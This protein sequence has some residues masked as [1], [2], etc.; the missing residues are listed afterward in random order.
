[1]RIYVLQLLARS[2]LEVG[3][4][5]G[6]YALYGMAVPS[7]YACSGPPCPHTVD[8]FVSRPTEKTIFL[9]IMYAVSLLCLALNFWEML[10]LGVGTICD[11]LGSQ[12]SPA[13]SNDEAS[14][15]YGVA[16]GPATEPAYGN[17][18]FSWNTPS[19]PPGYNFAVK[20]LLDSNEYQEPALQPPPAALPFTD[21]TNAKAACQQNR[22]NIA[23]EENQRFADDHAL[24]HLASRCRV[25]A[26]ANFAEV[27]HHEEFLDLRR[28]ELE[29]YT[30]SDELAVGKEEMVFEAVMRWVYHS[31]E[32][33]KPMLKELLHHV[34]MPLLHPNY[35]VQTVE[36]DHL[37]QNAPECYQ[38]LHEAR[39]YH[40]LG[41]EMMSP[42]TRPRR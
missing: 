36:G 21:L 29:E 37:I 41:N 19:A 20:P 6:Q 14:H 23:Q 34:R 33:R 3:F 24:K 31:L 35:F 26:L 10:H 27:A 5:L 9:L 1:M 12:R 38:L 28:E 42:R 40:V 30:A 25:Y 18:P 16:R 4:L 2:L 13:P 7:T 32:Q 8:C 39:R 15:P 17:V 22:A 11:I